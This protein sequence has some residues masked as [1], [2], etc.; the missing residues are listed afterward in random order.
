MFLSFV[1]NNL[2][3]FRVQAQSQHLDFA[4]VRERESGGGFRRF[5]ISGRPGEC[6]LHR[7]SDKG[8]LPGQRIQG[9]CQ[10]VF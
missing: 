9:R 6:T 8:R 10:E 5:R 2:N 4:R 7:I 3:N 1:S